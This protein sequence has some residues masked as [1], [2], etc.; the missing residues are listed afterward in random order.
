MEARRSPEIPLSKLKSGISGSCSTLI[1]RK[2]DYFCLG[3]QGFN[4]CHGVVR[5]G[6]IADNNLQILY[7]L[8]LHA[9]QGAT[10]AMCTI[11]RGNDDTD[12]HGSSKIG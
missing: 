1:D 6:I 8:C 4:N 7:S 2:A 9:S 10:D 11:V 5:R 12:E 3:H